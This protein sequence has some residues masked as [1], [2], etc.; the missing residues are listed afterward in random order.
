MG[1]QA[2]PPSHDYCQTPIGLQ[3]EEDGMIGTLAK[4]VAYNKAPRATFT[5]FHPRQ[6]LRLRRLRRDM[7]TSPAPRVAAIGAAVV[8]LPLGILLG[9]A[10]RG[11]S[12]AEM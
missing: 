3:L 5:I 2:S 9:R 7:M 11:R 4:M 12:D 10:G 8:A 1:R 6:A